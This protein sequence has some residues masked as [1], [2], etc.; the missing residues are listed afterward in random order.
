MFWFAVRFLQIL[1]EKD[2]NWNFRSGSCVLGDKTQR[3][4]VTPN[5]RD[6]E[7]TNSNKEQ[8]VVIMYL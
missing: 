7:I 6:T 3:W 4:S 2:K 8:Y 5:F 1:A